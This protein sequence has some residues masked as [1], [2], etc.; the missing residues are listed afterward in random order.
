MVKKANGKWRMCTDYIDLNKAYPKDPYSLPNIDQLVD[1][2][3][4]TNVEVYVGDIVVKSRAIANHY[5]ALERVFQ[6]LRKN[7]L[8]LNPEKCSFRVRVGK[9][10][11]FMLTERG[12][13][14][15]PEKCQAVIN[16]R[17]P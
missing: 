3:S 14:A 8:K 5:R 16:M 7:R 9:F 15:N 17:S 4:S 2:A 10:L 12:I 13:E 1:G 6:V 11:E